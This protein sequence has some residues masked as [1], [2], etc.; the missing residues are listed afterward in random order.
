MKQILGL[1]LLSG[2]LWGCAAQPMYETVGDVWSD[3]STGEVPASVH[4][5][6]PDDAQMEVMESL[7]SCKSYRIGNWILWTQVLDGGDVQQTL[8][9]LTGVDTAQ[10]VC[11]SIGAYECYEAV[12]SVMEEEG[13]FVIRTAVIPRGAYHYCLS[14]KSPVKE[15]RTMGEFFSKLL[16][17]VTI[18]DT[19]P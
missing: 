7:D 15:A 4:F 14:I 3:G 12:C 5:A 17:N 6:L 10:P 16:K 1:V 2:L 13:E 9:L 19:A 11:H 8:R 18:T